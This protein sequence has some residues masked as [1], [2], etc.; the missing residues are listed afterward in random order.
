VWILENNSLFAQKIQKITKISK[1]KKS[2]LKG[3]QL[4]ILR[5]INKNKK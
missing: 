4:K 2:L 5:I 1:L 3:G